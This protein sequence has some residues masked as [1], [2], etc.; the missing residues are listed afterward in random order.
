LIEFVIESPSG[1]IGY[2][3]VNRRVVF[4]ALSLPNPDIRLAE[5]LPQMSALGLGGVKTILPVVRE[6]D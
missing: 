3:S 1:N 2:L 6:R 5:Q 4:I